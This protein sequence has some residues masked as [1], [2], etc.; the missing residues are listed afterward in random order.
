MP[1]IGDLDRLRTWLPRHLCVDA[2]ASP[3]ARR[4]SEH[5]AHLLEER[6]DAELFA[7]VGDLLHWVARVERAVR[8]DVLH[9]ADLDAG[10]AM[11]TLLRRVTLLLADASTASHGACA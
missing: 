8:T 1:T 10:V 3:A 9:G 2:F 5:L 11:V 7:S 4:A 6:L